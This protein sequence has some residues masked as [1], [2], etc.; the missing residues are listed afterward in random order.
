[1]Y[2][3]TH[4]DDAGNRIR[5]ETLRLDNRAEWRGQTHRLQPLELAFLEIEPLLLKPTPIPVKPTGSP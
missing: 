2:R 5:I 1:M 4:Y 3:I